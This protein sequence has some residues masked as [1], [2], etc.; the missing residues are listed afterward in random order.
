LLFF[1]V[2][3]GTWWAISC[4]QESP[5]TVR[6]RR[7]LASGFF[8]IVVLIAAGYWHPRSLGPAVGA[9]YVSTFE[10]FLFQAS[11]TSQSRGA[12][13]NKGFFEISASIT[14]IQLI[15]EYGLDI[16]NR[17][18]A[19]VLDTTPTSRWNLHRLLFEESVMFGNRFMPEWLGVVHG[20]QLIGIVMLYL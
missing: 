14:L 13:I 6:P 8:A 5:H 4:A 15:R 17:L 9:F 2:E 19:L 11:S 20:L 16:F 12:K 3:F 1:A 7:S 10:K 18:V